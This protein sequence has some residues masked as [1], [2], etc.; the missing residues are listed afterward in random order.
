[1]KI[2][3]FMS[4]NLNLIYKAEF[5][6]LKHFIVILKINIEVVEV[7]TFKTFETEIS[8]VLIFPCCVFNIKVEKH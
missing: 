3:T 8:Q 1:M 5:Q 2:I 6:T 4:K 7:R